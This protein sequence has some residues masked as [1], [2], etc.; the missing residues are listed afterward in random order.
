[1]HEDFT[2]GILPSSYACLVEA[3][4]NDP[5]KGDIKLAL[6]TLVM[7]VTWL[8]G[9]AWSD[10]HL[11]RCLAWANLAG[12]PE[13][14]ALGPMAIPVIVSS[15]RFG[16]RGGCIPNSELIRKWV[17]VPANELWHLGNTVAWVAP[18]MQRYGV[19][20]YENLSYRDWV[21]EDSIKTGLFKLMCRVRS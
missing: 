1:M 4:N 15:Y 3:I 19:T 18:L 11:G 10:E 5:P 7:S 12:F 14:V 20:D 21:S 6:D 13:C 2:P 9:A 17:G 16:I 8:G